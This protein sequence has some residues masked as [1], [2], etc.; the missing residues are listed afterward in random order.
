MRG[1]QRPAQRQRLPRAR[2]DTGGEASSSFPEKDELVVP[3]AVVLDGDDPERGERA[4]M[5]TKLHDLIDGRELVRI[6][7][8]PVDKVSPQRHSPGGAIVVSNAN[9]VL[10]I[11]H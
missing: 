4:L 5:L 7:P 3:G 11:L 9:R 10:T 8:E 1:V 6:P 2:A